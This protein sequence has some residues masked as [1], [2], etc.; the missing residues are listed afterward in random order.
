MFKE[1]VL[2]VIGLIMV[3]VYLHGAQA[4]RDELRYTQRERYSYMHT[5][6]SW[7]WPL[8]IGWAWCK[9]VRLL[10]AQRKQ[11]RKQRGVTIEHKIGP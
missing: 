5:V 2:T 8:T 6:V 4:I 10:L 11:R 3:I 9:L 7:L 1:Q